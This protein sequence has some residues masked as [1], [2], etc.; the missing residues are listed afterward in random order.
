MEVEDKYRTLV[1][2]EQSTGSGS[3]GSGAY[4]SEEELGSD[5]FVQTL[6]DVHDDSLFIISRS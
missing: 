1:L 3:T 4:L 6:N 2:Q 5:A